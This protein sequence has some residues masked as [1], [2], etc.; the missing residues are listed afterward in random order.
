M[1]K[2]RWGSLNQAAAQF[3]CLHVNCQCSPVQAQSWQSR[4]NMPGHAWHHTTS[5]D[6]R[7]WDSGEI[8]SAPTILETIWSRE[9]SEGEAC[10]HFRV[11]S[12]CLAR[13]SGCPLRA[14][15]LPAGSA[16]HCA[17]GMLEPMSGSFPGPSCAT[18]RGQLLCSFQS[19]Y[20]APAQTVCMQGWKKPQLNEIIFLF[21][22]QTFSLLARVTGIKQ[23]SFFHSKP[24]GWHR[25]TLM[26]ICW[27]LSF[28]YFFFP[29]EH[30]IC[31]CKFR[32]APSVCRAFI[33]HTYLLPHY[34][35]L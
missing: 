7:N 26:L 22:S 34:A 18:I 12:R 23:G 3:S 17:F 28:Y 1:P 31:S 19:F 33:L 29:E 13:H 20:C 35:P 16:V 6:T 9:M 14:P 32:P 27:F 11:Q 30:F 21:S 15:L 8:T 25:L 5:K 24:S 2:M 4:T 10:H